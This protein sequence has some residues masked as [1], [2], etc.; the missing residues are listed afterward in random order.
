MNISAYMGAPGLK[1][2]FDA[3]SGFRFDTGAYSSQCEDHMLLFRF[4]H[5]DRCW[6]VFETFLV[7][8]LIFFALLSLHS[9]SM[10]I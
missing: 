4:V 10:N 1:V 8:V 2:L 7:G 9:R 5:F 6:Q 3:T